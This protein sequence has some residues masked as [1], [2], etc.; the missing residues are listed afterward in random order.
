MHAGAE[1]LLRGIRAGLSG[2]VVPNP[3]CEPPPTQTP[4]LP[5]V[6]QQLRLVRHVWPSGLH[7][8]AVASRCPASASATTA[9]RAMR[10]PRR[11]FMDAPP[12][13]R[14]GRTAAPR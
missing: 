9:S 4:L 14:E 6:P 1:Q 3:T 10:P 5:L 7:G 8:V 13:P 2:H 11:C 12:V